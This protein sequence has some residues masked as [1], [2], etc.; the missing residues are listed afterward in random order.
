MT[1]P[2][3]Q[4]D[5][6]ARGFVIDTTAAFAGVLLIVTA[7]FDVL[8]GLA[9]IA[10]PD[11]FAAGS[12][13]LYDFDVAA[14]GWVHLIIGVLSIVVGVAIL[15]AVTWGWILG[16][17]F[18]GLAALTNFLYLP[19]YPWWSATI[20]ALNVVNIWALSNKLQTTR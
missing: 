17:V 3:Q 5:Y 19:H 16:I 14:W 4:I 9:A 8:Q 7:C 1:T 20:I 12:A 13:Y 15:R 2:G 6:S 10:D 11:T 18:A